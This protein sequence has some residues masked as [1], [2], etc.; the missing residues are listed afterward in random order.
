MLQSATEELIRT[1]WKVKCRDIIIKCYLFID[2]SFM[3]TTNFKEE[4]P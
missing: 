2:D 3:H 1:S 4:F